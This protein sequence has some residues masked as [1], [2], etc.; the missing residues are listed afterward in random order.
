MM[1]RERFLGKG[2][3]EMSR[4]K[5]FFRR[6]PVL[7]I[8]AGC[9][10]ASALLV[11]P[12]P[13][14]WSYLDWRVL[15][16]LYCLMVVVSGL[17]K[18]GLFALLA[19]RLC[20]GTRGARG[21]CLLLVL[22]PFFASMAVT[23]DVAL[24][25]FVPFALLVLSLMGQGGLAPYVVALQTVAANLGSMATPVG[26]PQN[27]YL[28][29][30]YAMDPGQFFR[31]VLP[32]AG[33][34]ALV[35]CALVLPIPNRQVTVS[36]PQPARLAGGRVL[37][38]S[39]A[40]FPACLAAVLHLIPW[41]ACLALVAA[42]LLWADPSLLRQADFGLLATFV[43]FFLFA[44]N[45]GALDPVR[46]LLSRLLSG[47]ELLLSALASQ[48]ISNV[49]AALLLSGFTQDGRALLLGTNIG[50][51]GTPVASLASLIS[52]KA[53]LASPGARPGRYLAL[54]SAVNFGLLAL[55]LA[56][57]GLVPA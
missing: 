16:L 30:Y 12:S 44:G 52:L 22:L 21:V 13:A 46:S 35:L 54:F 26:N 7:V 1:E 51:L 37:W 24:I 33:A 36:F 23:N 18:A 34:S 17:R 20:G 53:Y 48:V 25:T 56:L 9:A 19:Q 28:Y 49:P 14:Y 2:G 31:A 29:S 11:P 5:R 3:G 55:L 8:S 45:L 6:E 32:V 10:L 42:V 38:A 27:L 15:G 50:G 4:L 43:C 57:A 41:P 39:L 40:L 47:R